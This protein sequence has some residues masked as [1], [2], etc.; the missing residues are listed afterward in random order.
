M[1][2]LERSMLLRIQGLRIDAMQIRARL[3]LA[4]AVGSPR[5]GHLR[6]AEKLAGKIEREEME[7]AN[8]LATLI[9][10]GVARQRGDDAR[11]ITLAEKA[12]KDFDA[13]HMRL[14]AVA[15][16]RRLGEMI[17]GDRGRQLVAQTEEWMSKQLI[18]NP[19]RMINMIA[20]GF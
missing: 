2:P 18:K 16:R 9:R 12:A 5:Q 3:A 20:P 10:A 4:S 17:G 6:L 14:Y 1:K 19:A 7:Y 15:A 13:V 8:P 11:A